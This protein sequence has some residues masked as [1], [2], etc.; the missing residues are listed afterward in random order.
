MSESQ[1]SPRRRRFPWWLLGLA[2]V[3]VPLV[4]IW[5]IIQV[6]Q[7]VGAWWTIGLLVLSGVLGSWLVKREGSRAMRAFR[8]ALAAGRLPHRELADGILVLVGGTLMLTPGFFSDVLGIL[9]ILPFTRPLGRRV[10]AGAISRRLV[11]SAAH[12]GSNEAG[13]RGGPMGA[14]PFRVTFGTRPAGTAGGPPPGTDA[15]R[16]RRRPGPDDVVQ[17]EVVD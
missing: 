7:V 11:G 16:T 10:L 3:V 15:P 17:G 2:F 13:A 4:E 5:T 9:M 6:G 8:E 1:P 14:G 12:G